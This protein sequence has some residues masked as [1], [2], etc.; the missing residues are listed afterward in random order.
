VEP[1]GGI[2]EFLKVHLNKH[3]IGGQNFIM[4]VEMDNSLEHR[5]CWD[6]R[7]I[8]S[9]PPCGIPAAPNKTG[10]FACEVRVS[11]PR[12]PETAIG[13]KGQVRKTH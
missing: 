1:I 12:D 13:R 5:K 2:A 11:S 4:Q 10:A 3:I 6:L 9:W 7:Q 8:H